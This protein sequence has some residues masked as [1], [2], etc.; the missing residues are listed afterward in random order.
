MKLER[1]WARRVLAE[2]ALGIGVFLAA[3]L[4]GWCRP[5]RDGTVILLALL[6]MFFLFRANCQSK[7]HLRC[8][9][10]GKDTARPWQRPGQTRYCLYCG[11]PIVFDDGEDPR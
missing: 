1:K 11:H 5:D 7:R 9:H 3:L 8:P 2:W 10:C 4:L 6:S